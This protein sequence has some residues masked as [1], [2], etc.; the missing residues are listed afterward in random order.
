MSFYLFSSDLKE[1]KHNVISRRVVHAG[2]E[3]FIV[4]TVSKSFEHSCDINVTVVR[5]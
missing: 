4:T 2:E 3:F 5:V 1:V